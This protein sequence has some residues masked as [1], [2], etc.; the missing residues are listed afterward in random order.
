MTAAPSF[1]PTTGAGFAQVLTVADMAKRWRC[2]RATAYRRMLALERKY[3]ATVIGRRGER[4]TL[5]TTL[6]AA[7]PFL[8]EAHA[9]GAGTL[10]QRVGEVEHRV[11]A[12]ERRVSQI[13]ARRP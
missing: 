7:R 4:G 9:V 13:D 8:L 5:Y 11:G 6:E 12:L 1:G 2:H 10:E 3:G